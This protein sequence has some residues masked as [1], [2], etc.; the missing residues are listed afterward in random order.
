MNFIW[1]QVKYNVVSFILSVFSGIPA[2]NHES[3]MKRLE[4]IYFL[5][6]FLFSFCIEE[7]IQLYNIYACS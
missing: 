1:N 3:L 4:V 7:E 6:V 2:E 5:Q